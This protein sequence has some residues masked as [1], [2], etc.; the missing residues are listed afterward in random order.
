MCIISYFIRD[1]LYPCVST[2]NDIERQTELQNHEMNEAGG[3][4]DR[5]QEELQELQELQEQ[6]KLE[7]KCFLSAEFCC[8]VVL[9]CVLFPIAISGVYFLIKYLLDQSS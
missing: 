8:T 7:Y 2:N 4:H 5:D 9:P 6:Q 3:D 1:C